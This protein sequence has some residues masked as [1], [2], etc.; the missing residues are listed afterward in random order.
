MTTEKINDMTKGK[1]LIEK[2]G[3]ERIDRVFDYLVDL[4]TKLRKCGSVFAGVGERTREGIA[5]AHGG[6]DV[7]SPFFFFN[8]C[9]FRNEKPER[10]P[11]GLPND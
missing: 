7:E 2:Y 3:T 11:N 6:Y 8:C 10:K 5:K 4:D 1:E 9:G